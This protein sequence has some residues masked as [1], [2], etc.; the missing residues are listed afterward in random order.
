MITINDPMKAKKLTVSLVLVLVSSLAFGQDFAFKVMANKGSNEVKSGDTWQP[1]K[2]G[3]SL[4]A[5]DELKLVDNAYIGLIHASGKPLEVRQSGNYK[6]SD[7]AAKVGGGSSVLN[8]YTDFILS[9]NAESKKNKLSATGAVHRATE[10]AAIKVMLPENQKYQALYNTTAIVKWD[11]SKAKGPYLVTLKDLF[12]DQ[13]AQ[14]ETPE[15]S[16]RLDL[17][18]PKFFAEHGFLVEIS[19]KSDPKQVSK[20][21]MITKMAPADREKVKND[22]AKVMGDVSEPTALNKFILAGF[23]EENNLLIDAIGAYEEAVKL[24]PSYQD[25]YDEFLLRNGLKK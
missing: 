10:T 20:Q 15:T 1:L 7:L 17:S 8:K 2:T 22:L 14:F 9:S 24:E 5:S 19:S 25:Y 11:G 18:D 6:V 13:I 4:K 23:Y 3:A 12:E 21:V 16:I